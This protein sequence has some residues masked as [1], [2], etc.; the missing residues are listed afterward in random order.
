MKLIKREWNNSFHTIVQ[1][2][3]SCFL[4]CVYMTHKHTGLS[5]LRVLHLHRCTSLATLSSLPTTLESLSLEMNWRLE[6]ASLPNLRDLTITR[7]PKLKRLAL[8]A[9]P[10]VDLWG[11]NSV[12]P[13]SLYIL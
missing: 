3:K 1:H 12:G 13:Q 9:L 11:S 8:H 4:F 6:D 10:K 2:K 5:S 7:C